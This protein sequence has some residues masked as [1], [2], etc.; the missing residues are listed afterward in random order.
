MSSQPLETAASSGCALEST[1]KR[2][3]VGCIGYVDMLQ[4]ILCL[5]FMGGLLQ[6]T[7]RTRQCLQKASCGEMR[8]WKSLCVSE[9]LTSVLLGKEG[10]QAIPDLVQRA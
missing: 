1:W 8:M 5:S 7:R 4:H 10:E 9:E 3:E 2:G 6:L